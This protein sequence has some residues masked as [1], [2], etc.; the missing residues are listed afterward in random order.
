MAGR[1]LFLLACGLAA[2]F[3]ASPSAVRAEP[4]KVETFAVSAR[5]I[6]N[7]Q[8][9][10]TES[11][12]GPLEFV[13]GL[14]LN[15]GSWDFGALSGFRFL[16]PGARF[17]G[18]TDTGFWYFG[19]IER[20]AEGRPSGVAGFSMQQMVDSNGDI[21]GEKWTTDAE[22]LAVRDGIATVGFERAHR[23]SEF[24]LTPDDMKG[25]LRDLDFVVPAYELRR[26]RG[27]ETVVH[28]PAD[29]AHAGA[30]IVVSEK[31]LDRKG[32]IFGAV[33]EGPTKGIFTVARSD[34][35]DI[36]DGA[37]LPG[38][39][40]LLLER[41]YS[42]AR[43]VAIRLKR[44]AG[45]AIRKGHRADGAVLLE[46]NMGYQIDN[47]EG[48]DVWRRADG[49]TM[50]SLISDDNHSILQRNLYLEFRLHGE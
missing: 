15:S 47:M 12:F 28:S 2:A 26:N 40:L 7:F 42:V 6:R 35:F 46:A 39:D 30:R 32:D 49:A 29:S 14:E 9:G 36:T 45:D 27:F 11:R 21:I 24:R 25:P 48:L 10:S 16:D 18:V 33:I 50:V 37:F 1:R 20:D 3:L 44:I 4:A 13:G 34:G 5:P 38:G 31:S 23:L 8:L 43:G 19:A 41:S 17:V 22:G